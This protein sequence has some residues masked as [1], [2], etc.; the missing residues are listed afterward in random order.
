[1]ADNQPTTPTESVTPTRYQRFLNDLEALCLVHQVTLE[2][3]EDGGIDARFPVGC[4]TMSVNFLAVGPDGYKSR[5][6]DEV[7]L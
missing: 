5:D 1:M 3:S 2:P 7:T 4:V 6:F